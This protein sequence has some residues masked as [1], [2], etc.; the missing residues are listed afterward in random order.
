MKTQ[1]NGE[2][3]PEKKIQLNTIIIHNLSGYFNKNLLL[4]HSAALLVA[5]LL[6]FML[7]DI[8]CCDPCDSELFINCGTFSVNYTHNRLHFVGVA[9]GDGQD[10]SFRVIQESKI[11]EYDLSSQQLCKVCISKYSLTSQ[12]NVPPL[13]GMNDIK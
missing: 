2:L 9:M 13:Y 5:F 8:F 12:Q 11:W 10:L 7:S 6:D 4:L 1:F 3:P